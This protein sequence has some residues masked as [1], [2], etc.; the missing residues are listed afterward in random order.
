M[1]NEEIQRVLEFMMQRQEVFVG[2]LERLEENQEKLQEE[3]RGLTTEVRG[4]AGLV[5]QLGEAQIQTQN[6][7]SHLTK[8]VTGIVEWRGIATAAVV[9][10]I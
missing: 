5:G 4:P 6:D 9:N 8:I 7:M 10:L 1:T 3:V 2:H